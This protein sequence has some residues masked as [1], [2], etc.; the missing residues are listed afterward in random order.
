MA[1]TV[2]TPPTPRDWIRLLLLTG[3][4]WK[5]TGCEKGINT[6]HQAFHLP[7]SSIDPFLSLP[8]LIR[9][10]FL[11]AVSDLS[12]PRSTVIFYTTKH[13]SLYC[14][15]IALIPPFPEWMTVIPSR[16]M[17]LIYNKNELELMIYITIGACFLFA[18]FVSF[19]VW[20]SYTRNNPNQTDL[21]Y[22]W[23][24]FHCI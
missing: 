18:Y 8:S 15:L 6:V 3:E 17:I 23:F 5:I 20:E 22:R 12:L 13:V 1:A 10:P 24:D 7:L 21:V 16:W 2:W 11:S 14:M 4:A 19:W 9:S